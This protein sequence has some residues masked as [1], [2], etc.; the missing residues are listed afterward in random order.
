MGD[1]TKIRFWED[2]W[3]GDQPLCSQ[4]PRL[5][6]V[7]TTK[8]LSISAILSNDTS[9]SWDL[10]F[11]RNLTD[12]EIEDP[13][14]SHVHLTP[15]LLD[16]K[17]WVLFSSRGFSIKYFL[18]VLFNFLDSTP[19]YLAHFLWKSRVPSK[20]MVFAWLVA[21]KKINTNGMLQLRRP[22]KAL[23]KPLALIGAFFVGVVVRW[24]IISSYIVRLLRD[25]GIG[26]SHRRGWRGF[27]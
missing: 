12:V 11:R 9:T 26:F 20:V 7:T 18:L 10:I 16:A 2:L 3:W 5:F 23:S 13:E 17:A 21:H 6:R 4:F 1:G 25:C 8:N 24:L 15:S 19:F 27:N 22:F 14:L